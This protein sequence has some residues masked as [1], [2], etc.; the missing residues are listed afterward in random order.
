MGRASE[1]DDHG[2]DQENP[3][4]GEGSAGA[5]QSEPDVRG[6]LSG[7]GND[8]EGE[9]GDGD[10]DAIKKYLW[11]GE[12]LGDYEHTQHETES[13]WATGLPEEHEVDEIRGERREEHPSQVEI[14][15]SIGLQQRRRK[16]VDQSADE[17]H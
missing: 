4:S 12:E 1:I 14:G 15:E 13:Y 8:C 3:G 7:I 9:H 6:E 5:Y 11:T 10:D 17:R 16:A 2:V